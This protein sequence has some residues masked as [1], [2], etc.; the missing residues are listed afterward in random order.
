MEAAIRIVEYD[1]KYAESLAEM[2]NRSGDSWGGNHAIRTA[3]SII[4]E[5]ETSGNLHVFLALDGEEVVGYCSFSHYRNDE[6][7]LYVPLLNVRPDY[8]GRKV[9]K[10]LVLTAVRKTVEL[11]WPRLDLFTWEGNTKAVPMYKKCGFF[12][13]KKENS[14][15]LMNFIPT[16]LRTEA[17]QPYFETVDWYEDGKR[18]LAIRPDGRKERGFDF[19]EYVWEK[20]DCT[21]RVEFEKSG[22]GLRLI[23]TEDYLIYA[24]VDEAKLVFGREYPVRYVIRN[25]SGKVLDVGLKG[26]DDKNIRFAMERRVLVEQ[27]AVVE[28]IF[29]LDPAGEDHDDWKT[30]PCVAAE[31]TINGKQAVFRTGIVP[32]PPAQVSLTMPPGECFRDAVGE[33]YLLVK[34][35]F[36][37]TAEFEFSLPDGDWIR[38]EERNHRVTLAAGDRSTIVVPYVLRDFGLYSVELSVKARLGGVGASAVSSSPSY[39]VDDSG[40]VILFTRKISGLFQGQDG[41]FGG[42]TEERWVIVNGSRSISLNKSSN[43]HR[44]RIGD[45]AFTLWCPPRFGRPYSLEFTKKKAAKVEIFQEHRTIGLRAFY[46]SQDFPGLRVESVV[47]LTANGIAERYYEVE[48]VS[49]RDMQGECWLN[50]IFHQPFHRGILPYEGEFIDLSEAYA[51][52]N[53]FWDMDSVTENWLFSRPDGG[54]WGFCWDPSFKPVKMDWLYGLEHRIGRLAPGQRERMPSTFISA[55]AYDDWFAFRDFA[56]KRIDP[57]R[58]RLA[59]HFELKVNGGNPFVSSGLAYTVKVSERKKLHL[60]GK[61]L[62]SS[63]NGAFDSL[64]RDLRAEDEAQETVFSLEMGESPGVVA[65][66]SVVSDLKQTRQLDFGAAPGAVDVVQLDYRSVKVDCLREKAVFPVSGAR[67]RS[68][69]AGES[70]GETWHFSNGPLSMKI[71]PAFGGALYSLEYDRRE[72]LDSSYP[73]PGPRS[74]WNPWFGGIAA[75]LPGISALSMQQEPRSAEFVL[76]RDNHGNEWQGTGLRTRIEQHEQLKGLE[77]QQYFLML[78][79]APVLVC[80]HRLRND[81]GKALPDFNCRTCAY[82][83]PDEE[84][85]S[86]WFSEPEREIVFRCGRVGSDLK[87]PGVLQYGSD[88]RRERLH[89]ATSHPQQH[90][91]AF[92]NNQVVLHEAAERLRLLPGDEAFSRPVF[93]VFRDGELTCEQVSD[94]VAIEFGRGD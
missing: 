31:L 22:R 49:G 23:E 53:Q 35:N 77:L 91:H 21:L 9:G 54:A 58:P 52:N 72:W 41:M 24:E 2:W 7:A 44:V 25:K 29:A 42:E 27:E 28:G 94:L 51:G 93:Y 40:D 64:S 83:R 55:G 80:V 62:L 56:R 84:L 13:E 16:V 68:F 88:R 63:Q 32:Q 38:F 59:G 66:S 46:E 18:D 81:T 30:A 14:T 45:R 65:P 34:N 86:A 57:Q 39:P 78:P 26:I 48:N 36:K 17:L 90:A 76:L 5:H 69:V 67:C 33:C 60:D 3:D 70:G 47:R 73:T 75:V 87:S 12:W 82:V 20:E 37:E 11:G 79:G 74:W 1:P 15:H 71:C 8:H 89:I 92:T 6:G 85:T 43:E 19:Y 10:S 4:Q 50:D 61:M